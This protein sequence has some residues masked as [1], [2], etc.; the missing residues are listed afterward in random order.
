[1]R[2]ILAGVMRAGARGERG[3]TAE[4][5]YNLHETGPLPSLGQNDPVIK[6]RRL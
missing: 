6:L 5:E 2:K 1:M 4:G 3:S